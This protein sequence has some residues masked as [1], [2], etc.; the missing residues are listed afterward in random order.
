MCIPLRYCPNLHSSQIV[1][2][3]HSDHSAVVSSFDIPAAQSIGPGVWKLNV[4][5][6]ADDEY[7]KLVNDFLIFWRQRKS[8]FLSPLVWWDVGKQRIKRISIKFAKGKSSKASSL[9]R[10]LNHRLNIVKSFIDRGQHNYLSEYHNILSSLARL[11]QDSSTAAYVRSRLQWVEEGERST[12][13]FLRLEKQN[14]AKCIIDVIEDKDQHLFSDIDGMMNVWR[15]FYSELFSCQQTDELMHEAFLDSLE[16]HLPAQS[17][18]SCEGLLS[19]DECFAAVAGMS[20]NKTPGI[21]GLPKEFY[22]AFWG[23]LGQDLVEVFNFAFQSGALTHSQRTGLITILHKK[24]PRHLCSNYRPISLLCTDYKIASKAISNRL[25]KVIHEVV[26]PD[27][28]CS[29]PGRYI[30]ENIRLLSDAVAYAETTQCPLAV[31]SLDQEKA[32]DRVDWEFMLQV[33][34]RMGFGPMFCSWVQLFYTGP[35]ASVI[36]NGFCSPLFSLSRGVRQGCPLSASLYVLVS[37]S[38]A[39]CLRESPSLHGLTLPESTERALVS[40]YADDMAVLCTSDSD[41]RAVFEIFQLYEQASGAKLSIS[42]CVGLWAGSWVGRSSSPVD[43]K[44]T[45]SSISC[46]GVRVGNGDLHAEIW[47]DRLAAIK[48]TLHSWHQRSLTFSG[49]TLV[50]NSL[51]LSKLWY[52]ASVIEMPTWVLRDVRN[53][54]FSFF[55]SGK[56]E[57]VQRITLTLPLNEGGYG[58]AD[59]KCKTLSLHA[60]W[61][62]RFLASSGKWKS[63]FSFFFQ[64][65][66]GDSAQT[67]LSSP[68]YYPAG[69]LPPFY[70]SVLQSWTLIGGCRM[71]DDFFF[72]SKGVRTPLASGAAKSFHKELASVFAEP[73]S[74]ISRFRPSFGDLYCAETWQQV[75]LMPLDRKVRDHSWKIAHGALYTCDRLVAMGKSVD[76]LCFCSQENETQSHLFFSCNF[77]SALLIWAYTIFLKITPLCPTL[78]TRHMLFGFDE[79]EREIVPP[80]FSYFLNLLKYFVWLQRNEYRFNN[81]APDIAK[82][83]AQVSARLYRH[84]LSLSKKCRTPRQK[85]KFNRAWNVLG[86][87]S[88]DIRSVNFQ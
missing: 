38:L 63:L 44:W 45:S 85:R 54:M 84:L 5:L 25:R 6:L 32:F 10:C 46:L 2:C 41:I 51:I 20:S 4:S 7:V 13:F 80:V 22:L 29:I 31:L 1:P 68:G 14:K 67:V 88:P 62:K 48:R 74:C 39:C 86:G 42:K 34:N 65:H 73:P 77:M 24:G 11:D 9:R 76:P 50:L 26:S 12:S 53:M 37:E 64:K 61:V 71:G 81:T 78:T 47:Q 72:T 23:S 70:D 16:R 21:D 17:A 40:Q 69:L 59:P 8:S 28:T 79:A 82:I 49:K 87:F 66:L 83:R 30:G 15:T 43:I 36:V 35:M 19:L 56:A 18:A 75:H 52:T 3:P 27:Q 58:L 57:R 33:L 55:W 60:M